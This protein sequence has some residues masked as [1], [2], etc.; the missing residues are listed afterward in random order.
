M[1]PAVLHEVAATGAAL[2]VDALPRRR[3]VQ[4]SRALVRVAAV[5]VLRCCAALPLAAL[6]G[7]YLALRCWYA[8][9]A[10]RRSMRD[11]RW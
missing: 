5:P 6:G 9:R 7:S 2:I 1:I 8:Y 11:G 10:A 3:R 4:A